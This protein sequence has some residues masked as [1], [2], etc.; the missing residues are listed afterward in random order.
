MIIIFIVCK[1]QI[2]N[3]CFDTVSTFQFKMLNKY[4]L[5]T[6]NKLVHLC[7]QHFMLLK[8]VCWNVFILIPNE[9][10]LCGF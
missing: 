7:N 9:N 3:Y 1:I 10:I 5:N 4:K 2:K 8:M 6:M